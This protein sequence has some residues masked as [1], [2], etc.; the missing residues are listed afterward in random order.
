[1]RF[2]I[3]VTAAQVRDEAERRITARWPLWRQVNVMREGGA[4]LTAMASEIDAIRAASNVL[5]RSEPIP[6]DYA[7][8]RHW[9]R[10]E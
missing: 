3:C 2:D 8:D 4:A 1:M 7:D 10:G 5:E 6:A 9:P